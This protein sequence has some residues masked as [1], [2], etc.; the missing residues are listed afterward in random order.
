[1]GEESLVNFN[2]KNGRENMFENQGVDEKKCIKVG[3][4]V[5]G[6]ECVCVCVGGGGINATSSV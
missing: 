2:L 4:I 5:V 1:V 3:L 6:C